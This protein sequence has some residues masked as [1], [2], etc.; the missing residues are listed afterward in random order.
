MTAVVA[1]TMQHAQSSAVGD[2]D[3]TPL[4]SFIMGHQLLVAPQAKGKL[5]LLLTSIAVSCKFVAQAVRKAGVA[6]ILGMAGASNVQG[7]QQKKLDVIANDVF[8]NLLKKSGQCC[9]LVSE[10][11][12]EPIFVEEKFRGE[13]AVVFDPLD[14]SSNIDCGVSIGSIFGIYRVPSG[15]TSEAD[16]VKQLLQPGSEMVAAGYCQY[17]SCCNLVFSLGGGV[18]GFT[19]DPSLGEFV[20]THNDIRVPPRG[21]IYS[22]NEGN[23]ATW[24]E[25]TRKYVESC[26][27][28]D[29]GG[30]PKSLRYVGS[31]VAD[32]HRTLLYGGVFMYPA[33][34]KNAAGKLR[35]LYE[36]FP[37]AFLMEQAGGS[38]STGKMRTLDIVPT[39]IHGRAPIVLGS[40]DDVA[41]IERLY[42]ECG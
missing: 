6:G 4:S 14:G 5:N 12:E 16:C 27:F 42:A 35:L 32:V 26:K 1:E 29:G 17:G 8:V 2:T 7:E 38:A 10:E 41:A 21:T 3:P 9:V 33:D 22:I 37:M 25:P 18:F 30:V 39:S 24:D 34:K 40:S 23:A 36:C 20:L 13:Y 11:E 19:L 15:C 31:M 28:P